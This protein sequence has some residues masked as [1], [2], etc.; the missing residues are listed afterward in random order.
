MRKDS[1][2]HLLQIHVTELINTSQNRAGVWAPHAAFDKWAELWKA[3]AELKYSIFPLFD[4]DY[5]RKWHS[6]KWRETKDEWNSPFRAWSFFVTE[7][8]LNKQEPRLCWTEAVLLLLYLYD[9][10]VFN[11]FKCWRQY[12]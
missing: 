7:K 2:N 1:P 5:K 4:A 3:H 12:M 10:D 9:A 11:A 8:I 6:L